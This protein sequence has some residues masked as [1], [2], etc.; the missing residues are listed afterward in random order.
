MIITIDFQ[1]ELVLNWICFFVLVKHLQ[2]DTCKIE[3]PEL[4]CEF[5]AGGLGGRFT[6]IEGVLS[7]IK[8]QVYESNAVFQDSA[9]VEAKDKIDK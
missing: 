2:S 3:I 9:D 6:T 8:D 7:A 4:D 1:I 5:G